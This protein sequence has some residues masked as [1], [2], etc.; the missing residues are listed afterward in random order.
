M[1]PSLKGI[2]PWLCVGTAFVA[3]ACGAVTRQPFEPN[4][5]VLDQYDF[6]V[7]Q[8]YWPTDSDAGVAGTNRKIAN[9]FD[10]SDNTPTCQISLVQSS[11]LK[12]PVCGSSKT[13][14]NFSYAME[15][16][17]NTCTYWGAGASHSIP[18][19]P[20]PTDTTSPTPSGYY[21]GTGFEGIA[22]WARTPGASFN[23]V[24]ISL[25]DADTAPQTRNPV[26]L[27][28]D[29]VP[30]Q[31]CN[32]VPGDATLGTNAGIS[33]ANAI[34][35]STQAVGSVQNSSVAG[36]GVAG[37]LPARIP[38]IGECGNAFQRVLTVTGDW[39]LY[40]LP[41]STFYQM[42][43]P[44]LIPTGFDPTTTAE[45]TITFSKEVLT[46]LWIGNMSFYRRHG[47]GDAGL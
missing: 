35:A 25:N 19:R 4:C 45:V 1:R 22:I 44:N 30:S 27:A 7:F 39:Q 10:Y 18:A 33:N 37:G 47:L 15:I 24:V 17:A 29:R 21:D 46:D 5:S 23:S 36:A 28:L 41:F 16:R 11:A 40:F 2:V 12:A 14:G 32:Q 38:A 42:P 43:Y 8:E 31:R 6:K 3:S 20:P 13:P 26:E 34:A 9:W